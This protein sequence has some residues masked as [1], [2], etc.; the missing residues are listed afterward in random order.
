MEK[1][2]YSYNSDKRE[3]TKPYIDIE[4]KRKEGYLYVHGG[5]KGTLLKF[6]FF[7]PE[8]KDYKGRFFQYMSPV[9]GSEDAAIGREG[10]EDRIRF[11]NT[12]G[13]YYIESNMGAN[14]FA[15]LTDSTVIYRASAAA[16]E[17]SREV[18]RRLYGEHRPYGYIYGGSGGSFKTI[19]CLE[20]TDAWDG[21]APY[22]TG[23][24]YS[25]P[26][27]MTIRT[28]AKRVLRNV[29]PLIADY[30]EPGG[31]NKEELYAKLTEEEISVLEESIR[32]GFPLRSW[33]MREYL[34]DGSL[35]VFVPMVLSSAPDY[36]KDFWEKEGYLGYDKNGSARRDRLQFSA[37]TEEIFVPGVSNA[38]TS[39]LTGVD[40]AW[41]RN[42][43]QLDGKAW[44]RIDKKFTDGTYIDGT[45]ITV[46][47]GK[48]A[49][50]RMVLASAHG[51]YAFIEP[52]FGANDFAEKLALLEP[53]DELSFDNSDYIALQ[54]LH[55]HQ[56]PD[57]SFWAWNVYRNEDGTPKYPQQGEAFGPRFARGGCGS[58]QSGDFGERKMIAVCALMDE[59]ALPWQGDWY[60]RKVREA[61]GDENPHYRLWYVDHAFHGDCE[62]T[63]DDL[64]LVPYLGVLHQALL[65]VADWVERGI[66]PEESSAYTVNDG[67]VIVSEFAAERKGVQPIVSLTVNDGKCVHIKAGKKVTFAASADIPTA[68]GA[69]TDAEWSF[70]GE[71]DFPEKG[72]FTQK[73]RNATATATHVYSKP[74]TYF[75]VVRFISQLHKQNGKDMFTRIFNI[76]RVRV[77]VE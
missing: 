19:S 32:F 76:D 75:A 66:A 5:F 7:F 63:P 69:V 56:T 54:S 9:Q 43:V 6:S 40:D 62:R 12:H 8:K 3:F 68:D 30:I 60:R 46:K 50:Y 27:S 26:Y 65:S 51:A 1:K 35:P 71:N 42:K 41:L 53:G 45:H 67:E 61:R 22:V 2:T 33:C 24:P 47:S 57:G 44:M 48:A 52:F 64:H 15:P 55:R 4:E 20:N 73:E 13:A 18:A 49:G 16:A 70:E 17:Y 14:P 10:M 36:F 59:S 28:H 29:F 31:I 23:T 58:L 38:D 21:A 34:D 11:A 72:T 25:I 77:V 74:G 37:K 39:S